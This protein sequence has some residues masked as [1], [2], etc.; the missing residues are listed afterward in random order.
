MFT[1]IAIVLVAFV[2]VAGAIGSRL[3]EPSAVARRRLR[4]GSAAIVDREVVTL[5]GTVRARSE[6][7]EA[8]LTGKRC[9]LYDSYGHVK[10]LSSNQRYATT[11]AEVREQKMVPFE[12]EVDGELVLVDG[13]SADV[14]LP[15]VP[16]VPRKI[17]R[18]KAFLEA[19]GQPFKLVITSG[20]DEAR[21]APGDRV[22]VQGMAIIELDQTSTDER[23]YR[24]SAPRKI[25]LVAH[26]A[27]PLTIGRPRRR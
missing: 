18:E 16:V 6:L 23:G 10:E 27:H 9:V 12:L 14:E 20:F 11:I 24:E 1:A 2:A 4:R 15:A 17:E 13:E 3:W 21:V 8:P 5:V 22:S 19:H 25:R 7:L 26:A